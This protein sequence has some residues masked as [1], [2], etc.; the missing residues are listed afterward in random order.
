MKIKEVW[1]K[2]SV[3]VGQ[4]RHVAAKYLFDVPVL[5]SICLGLRCGLVRSL[6]KELHVAR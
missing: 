5:H 6:V 3:T 1:E 2:L 4:M